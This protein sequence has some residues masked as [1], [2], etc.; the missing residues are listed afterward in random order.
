MDRVISLTH[1]FHP[2][3]IN[4]ADG[5]NRPIHTISQLINDPWYTIDELRHRNKAR[6][7][8]YDGEKG[9][10]LVFTPN[11]DVRES[12]NYYFLEGEFPGIA[13][14]SDIHIEWVGHRTLVVEARVAKLDEEAE[15]AI[16]HGD[17]EHKSDKERSGVAVENGHGSR[18]ETK[19]KGI[20]ELLNDRHM[21]KLQRS[22]TFPYKVDAENLKARLSNGLLKILVTKSTTEEGEP[23]KRIEIE[24]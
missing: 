16:L 23:R 14:K 22:F 10:D 18:H 3:H 13:N 19:G 9:E 12:A 8:S 21:G 11:F 6:S 15:W 1:R 24:D 7:P 17:S 4:L 2:E 20:R 5:S